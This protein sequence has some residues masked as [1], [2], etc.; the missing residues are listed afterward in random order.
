MA[1]A[2]SIFSATGLP[3]ETVVPE[4]GGTV[5]LEMFDPARGMLVS[6]VSAIELLDD[7]RPEEVGLTLSRRA[8]GCFRRAECVLELG[9]VH[10]FA[11]AADDSR[12]LGG[13]SDTTGVALTGRFTASREFAESADWFADRLAATMGARSRL[14]CSFQS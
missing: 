3:S 5:A 14:R 2:I 1:E 9:L 7:E 11:G 6:S 12:R 13:P 10:L 4:R 8:A